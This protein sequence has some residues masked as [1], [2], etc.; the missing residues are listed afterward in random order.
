[1]LYRKV[2]RW[3][4]QNEKK[5][6]QCVLQ[7]SCTTEDVGPMDTHCLIFPKFSPRKGYDGGRGVDGRATRVESQKQGIPFVINTNWY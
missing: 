7:E 1:V 3:R 4:T 2:A 6:R 5:I